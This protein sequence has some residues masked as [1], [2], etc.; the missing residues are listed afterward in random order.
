MYA[1][2]KHLKSWFIIV[3]F[4]LLYYAFIAVAVEK[5][6]ACGALVNADPLNAC[7]P[8]RNGRRSNETDRARFALIVRGDCAF[9][10]K[11]LNAQNAGFGA[12]IVY[13]DGDGRDLVYSESP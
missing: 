3:L 4:I 13:D 8:L 5:A 7:S 6:G 12:A 9:K 1:S 10:D 2:A 11:I